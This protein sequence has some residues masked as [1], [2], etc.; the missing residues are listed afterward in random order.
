MI[1]NEVLRSNDFYC[2]CYC[3]NICSSRFYVT[4]TAFSVVTCYYIMPKCSSK[5]P[6][7]QINYRGISLSCVS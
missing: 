5:G 3:C 6:Y 1:L 4:L 2:Y 7:I